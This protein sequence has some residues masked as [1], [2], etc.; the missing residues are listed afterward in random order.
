MPEAPAGPPVPPDPIFLATAIEAVLEAGRI[1]LAWFGKHGL[2]ID[3]KGAMREA[4]ASN[5]LP[6]RSRTIPTHCSPTS[7]GSC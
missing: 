4:P 3:K 5:S 7:S 6:M 1:Q 2:R